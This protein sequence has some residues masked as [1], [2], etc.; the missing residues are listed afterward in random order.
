MTNERDYSLMARILIRG[1]FA[2]MISLLIWVVPN[3]L[4]WG[5]PFVYPLW[6]A[7]LML[8]S[9]IYAVVLEVQR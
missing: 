1:T 4:I 6:G 3:M 2:I 9:I 7:T 5:H 8:T